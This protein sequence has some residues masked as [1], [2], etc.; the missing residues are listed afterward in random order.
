VGRLY[1]E[2][3]SNLSKNF[4]LGSYTLIIALMGVKYGTEEWTYHYGPLLHV[5][6]HPHRWNVS[7]LRGEKPQNQHLSNLNTGALCAAR[8]AAGNNTAAFLNHVYV[9]PPA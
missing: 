9:H 6:F 5:K 3:W 2:V 4:T 1:S 7:P 8:N